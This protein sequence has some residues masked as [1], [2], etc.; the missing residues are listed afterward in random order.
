M[1]KPHLNFAA[2][3]RIVSG[4]L[5]KHEDFHPYRRAG[6]VAQRVSHREEARE[7]GPR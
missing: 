4:S 5:E 2:A 1:S 6:H 3:M 7:A